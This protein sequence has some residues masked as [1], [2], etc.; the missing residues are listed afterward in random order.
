M[1][2][3]VIEINAPRETC[4]EVIADFGSYPEFLSTTSR[5]DVSKTSENLLHASFAVNVIREISYTLEFR[6]NPP[7]GM[8][9]SL[10]R[11][12]LMSRNDGSWMFEAIT[13]E[14]TRAIY[15]IDVQF[16]WLVPKKI[17]EVLTETQLPELMKS[18]KERV[19]S[20]ANSRGSERG[21][22]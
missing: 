8:S 20:V 12:D 4:F 1:L 14:K 18:F 11:G 10:V 17:V 16:G 7:V 3:R 2:E 19:E 5:V 22:S 9:W 21:R 13:P 6:L 15:R